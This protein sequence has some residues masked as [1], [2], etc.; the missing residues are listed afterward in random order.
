VGRESLHR[1]RQG[2][3]SP[4][5]DARGLIIAFFAHSTSLTMTQWI[6]SPNT[7]RRVV[8]MAKR[9]QRKEGAWVRHVNRRVAPKPCR[10]FVAG[11][12]ELAEGD[13][14]GMS[15]SSLNKPRTCAEAGVCGLIRLNRTSTANCSGVLFKCNQ[16]AASSS[17]QYPSRL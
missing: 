5:E 8:G 13:E 3:L 2:S 11:D 12:E 15:R 1:D 10:H 14:S 4:T 6:P 16:T 17:T 9:P 7:Q